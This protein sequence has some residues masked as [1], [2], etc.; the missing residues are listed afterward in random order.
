MFELFD[1]ANLKN[2]F[3]TTSDS[4]KFLKFFK[5]WSSSKENDHHKYFA[6]NGRAFIGSSVASFASYQRIF[7]H[8]EN[9]VFR[10]SD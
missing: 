5:F 9:M 2:L 3:G 1:D 6:C 8:T 7:A 4:I 10:S